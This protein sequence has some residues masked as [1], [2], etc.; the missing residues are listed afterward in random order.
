[1]TEES[2]LV[3]TLDGP[4]G[5]GKSTLAKRV[6][7]ALCVA[8]LDTG[9]MFRATALALGPHGPNMGEAELTLLLMDLRFTLQ[10][11]GGETRLLVNGRAVGDEIRSEEVS[12]LAS[13]IATVPEVRAFQKQAQQDLGRS[14]SL[15]AE[16]RDMGTVIFPQAR[17]KFFLDARPEVRAMRR[18]KQYKAMGK[19]ADLT[20]LEASIRAR[21]EQDRTRAVAP[22]KPA[23]DAVIIDTSDLDRD[24]VFEAIMAHVR[25][26]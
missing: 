10:G 4:A 8:Y 22:L 21:D 6:A 19:D 15:V 20:E 12:M 18:F 16:G 11:S 26:I 9:A 23:D 13:K 2:P 24:Q 14:V 7:D 17:H 5:V 1:M 25:P 3:V